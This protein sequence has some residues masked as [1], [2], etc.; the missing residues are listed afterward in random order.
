VRKL[1]LRL[2]KASY[3]KVVCRV[4]EQGF[5]VEQAEYYGVSNSMS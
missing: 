3:A 5:S 1:L 4:A 2:N